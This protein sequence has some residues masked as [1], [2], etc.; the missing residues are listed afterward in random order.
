M[1]VGK[2]FLGDSED[3]DLKVGMQPSKIAVAF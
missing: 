3:C 2:A 1:H